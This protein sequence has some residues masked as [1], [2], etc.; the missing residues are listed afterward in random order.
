MDNQ[1]V[2]TKFLLV[3]GIPASGFVVVAVL[4]LLSSTGSIV[5]WVSLGGAVVSV[6][7]AF[8]VGGSVRSRLRKLTN[9]IDGSSR[10]EP[11]DDQSTDEIGEL[12]RAVGDLSSRENRHAADLASWAS[13]LSETLAA[14]SNRQRELL[15]RQIERIDWLESTEEDPER[16]EQLFQLDHLA[17][18]IRR[19]CESL[20]V[21]AGNEA[22]YQRTDPAPVVDIVRVAA[23][24]NSRYRDVVI[25]TMDDVM[26]DGAAAC[27]MSL[28][29]GEL[30]ENA[31]S[32]SPDDTPVEV[33]ATLLDDGSY[34]VIVTDR[35]PGMAEQLL[36][37]SRSILQ[38]PSEIQRSTDSSI[39]LMVVGRLAG[40]IGASVELS[41]SS[42]SGLTAEVV[43]PAS[44]VSP[45]PRTASPSAAVATSGASEGIGEW[46]APVVQPMS[47]QPLSGRGGTGSS[48][49]P[50]TGPAETLDEALAVG[51]ALDVDVLGE[52]TGDPSGGH[53]VEGPVSAAL[54]ATDGAR[55]P[56]ARTQRSSVGE[57]APG[58]DAGSGS[59][60]D[61]ASSDGR[62]AA[63]DLGLTR[64]KRNVR[65]GPAP[66]DPVARASSRK[67]DEIRSMITK[68]RDGL[69]ARPNG[70]GDGARS[71]DTEGG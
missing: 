5:A 17:T 6:V 46:T 10:I 37:R 35:G 15:D 68:Y 42:P 8:V 16:L 54:L 26:I 23:G 4:S 64:R 63:G 70:R 24:Q 62:A 51:D 45:A 43:I 2:R 71:S 41:H 34:R 69:K 11:L 48:T 60:E 14:Q 19:Q 31:T 49:K 66:A 53:L 9:S 13:N 29:L 33:H 21:A 44:V 3:A 50:D 22:V 18:R 1:S 30:L 55:G 28:M 39:G 67:P 40:R 58:A 59:E 20:M 57:P 52:L 38:D 25:L 36:D 7:F 47:E 65:V 56:E 61:T 32:C 27:D 12:S